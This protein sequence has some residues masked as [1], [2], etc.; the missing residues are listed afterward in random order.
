MSK[1][2]KRVYFLDECLE[3]KITTDTSMCEKCNNTTNTE[4]EQMDQKTN[5]KTRSKNKNRTPRTDKLKLIYS[6]ANGVNSKIESIKNNLQTYESDIYCITETKLQADPPP[7][8]GY[9]W[10]TKNRTNRQGGGVAILIKNSQK[11]ITTRIDQMEDQNQEIIWIEIKQGKNTTYIG[12]YYGPQKA[13]NLETIE[14]EFS[15]ITT[16]INRI[17]NKGRIILTGDFNAKIKVD[18]SDCMQT[19]SKNGKQLEKLLEEQN[20]TATNLMSEHG[21]WTRQ[22]R[23]NPNERSVIDYILVDTKT[24][25]DIE[26]IITDEVG[27]FRLKGI[28]ES[29][30]NTILTTIN[31]QYRPTTEKV[32]KWKKPTDE[33]WDT[34]N[35]IMENEFINTTQYATLDKAIITALER[36]IGTKTIYT[37][38]NN[39]KET[40]EIKTKRKHKNQMKKDYN[41]AIQNKTN[42]NQALERYITSQRELKDQISLENKT[43]T[44]IIAKKLIEQ[45]G[46]K[47]Q[48]F[49]KIKKK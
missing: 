24:A 43:Q 4:I 31:I 46:A 42:V 23:K 27:T 2:T 47:S 34:F 15:Q 14:N 26:E 30:H 22:N 38:K 44:Q 8:E 3:C 12:T 9:K 35:Q 32:T 6:N 17:K 40:P 5:K 21:I 11:N 1:R 29:D 18:R 41:K 28:N 16:Q 7:I 48:L 39:K 20:L 10:E 37:H 13:T 45:G 25:K 33:N 36:A 19:T 49:W